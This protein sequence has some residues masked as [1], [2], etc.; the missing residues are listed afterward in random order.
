[1][2]EL[3]PH[4]AGVRSDIIGREILRASCFDPNTPGLPE[5]EAARVMDVASSRLS[6]VRAGPFHIRVHALVT[7]RA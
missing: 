1:M 7:A 5:S 2:R 6:G 4:N 3:N